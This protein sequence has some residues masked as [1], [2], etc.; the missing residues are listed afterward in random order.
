MANGGDLPYCTRCGQRL[1]AT[2]NFCTRCGTARFTPSGAYDTQ[3]A[4]RP[5]PVNPGTSTDTG[6][7]TAQ[8]VRAL[9]WFF[10]L[11]GVVLTIWDASALAV[12][13][14]PVG[15]TQLRRLAPGS[16]LD[17]VV[18]A[19]LVVSVVGLIAGLHAVAFHGLRARQRRGWVSAVLLAVVWSPVV[20]GIPVLWR[21]LQPRV[22]AIF[23]ERANR[24]A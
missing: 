4:E 16:S 15:Q 8:T 3:P 17:P 2:S 12:V 18:V 13:L 23:W 22:R 10:A 20:V 11:G 14:N 1:Q 5:A 24:A 9:S 19:G 7:T 6:P 21:L